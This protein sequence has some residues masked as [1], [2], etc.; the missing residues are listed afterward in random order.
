MT[1]SNASN[2][3][4]RSG[5]EEPLAAWKEKVQDFFRSDWSRLRTLMMELEEEAWDTGHDES[6]CLAETSDGTG[7]RRSPASVVP[8]IQQNCSLTPE[9]PQPMVNDRLS[10]LAEQIERRLKTA[11][12]IGR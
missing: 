5:S 1:F 8:D 4:I 10:Q 12:A 6:A 11:N 3:E 2:Q 7:H 9:S